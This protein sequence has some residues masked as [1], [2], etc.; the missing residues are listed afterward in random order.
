MRDEERWTVAGDQWPDGGRSHGGCVLSV[1]RFGPVMRR[2]LPTACCLL[3]STG[4]QAQQPRISNARLQARQVAAGLEREVRSIADDASGP[5]WIGYT[6]PAVPGEHLLCCSES[7]VIAGVRQ[8]CDGCRLEGGA[9]TTGLGPA[10]GGPVMLEG[11]RKILVMLRVENRRTEKVRTF[12]EDCDLDAGGLPVHWLEGVRAPDSVAFLR[13]L[14]RTTVEEK[15][16]RTE[17]GRISRGALTAIAFHADASAGGALEEFVLVQNPLWL[18]KQAAFWL[19]STRGQEGFA[20]L[21]RL[22][23]EDS[24]VPFRREAVFAISVSKA[25]EATD[26]LMQVA[27]HDTSAEVRAQ[28]LFWL[29]QK[30]GARVAGT[31]TDAIANDPDTQV[32][33]RAVFALSQLPKD[34]GVPLL[35]EVAR[36]NKNPVVRKRAVFWL[37]QSKD[38][39]ALAFIEQVLR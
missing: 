24:S 18:R 20:V 23:Q 28:A 3:L 1:W 5:A 16:E 7:A 17:E 14:V 39:R 35:I 29:A 25:P 34:E 21:R 37:G 6:V 30:A 13:S 12:S 22:V 2:L 27:R 19:G 36:T 8:T 31:I 15:P 38:P 9:G 4:I 33:E 11:A 32:K 10:I 26:T